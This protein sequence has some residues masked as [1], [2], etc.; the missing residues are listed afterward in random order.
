MFA[1][2]GKKQFVPVSRIIIIIFLVALVVIVGRGVT[3]FTTSLIKLQETASN[4]TQAMV[5]IE[6]LEKQ[7]GNCVKNLNF[8]SDLFSTCRSELEAGK[9]E[10]SR[11]VY[12]SSAYERNITI[13][14]DRVTV[15]QREVQS[16]Q[17]LSE[18]MAA[19][20][21]C[22]RRYVLEDDTL[23]YYYIRENKT[24]CS[25]QPDDILGTREFSC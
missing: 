9:A 1:D 22:L 13:Y 19:T 2:L 4:A 21:C 25:S 20:I 8:T 10:N 16:L 24:F 23:R 17:G 7:A 11:L 15:L 18:N 12:E 3:G 6:T 14:A 5:T